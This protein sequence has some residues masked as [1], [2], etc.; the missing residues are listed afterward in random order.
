MTAMTTTHHSENHNELRERRIGVAVH[1][2]AGT[3]DSTVDWCCRRES[4]VSYNGVIRWDG[5]VELIVPWDRRAWHM[6]PCDP[7]DP[8]RLPYV[9]AN[10]AFEG[11]AL[12]G[13][14]SF[15]PPTRE[16]VRALVQLLAARFDAHAWPRTETWRIV[17]HETE[18]IYTA[19]DTP[20]HALWG[21]KG[22]K[23]D[24]S[25]PPPTWGRAH[26]WLDLDAI[27]QEV[28]RARPSTPS[29]AHP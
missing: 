23:Q 21:K 2:S 20:D 13:G 15:G 25:G 19:K 24:P 8:R 17:G 1:Y 18:R 3:Y 4:Q 11:I 29:P 6:G 9:D 22:A 16:A 14:P 28:A 10:S 12:A 27:R 26:P 5:H 7:S